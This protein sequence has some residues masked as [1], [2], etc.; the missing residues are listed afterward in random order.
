M[1]GEKIVLFSGI[2]LLLIV[3]GCGGGSSTRCPD[4]DGNYVGI[5]LNSQS[6]GRNSLGYYS[7]R[8]VERDIEIQTVDSTNNWVSGRLNLDM[9]R[10]RCTFVF[11]GNRRNDTIAVEYDSK[12]ALNEFKECGMQ[13]E[14]NEIRVVRSTFPNLEQS[15]YDSQTQILD[16]TAT[17]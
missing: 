8:F 15:R 17:L 3:A 6:G 14:I 1:K 11:L 4:L 10:T 2:I 13:L 9:E 7:I 5:Y 12:I 16:L